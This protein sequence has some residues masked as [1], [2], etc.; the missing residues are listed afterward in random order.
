MSIEE[1]EAAGIIT[2]VEFTNNIEI[3]NYT[4]GGYEGNENAIRDV[5]IPSKINGKS[6]TKIDAYAFLALDSE[7]EI[8]ENKLI[9]SIVIPN[10]V[11]SIEESAFAYNEL[12]SVTIPKS[13]TA[14]E[15]Y[16]FNGNNLE[17]VN[18]PD[19]VTS[20]GE[21]AFAHNSLIDVVIPDNVTTIGKEAFYDCKSLETVRIGNSVTSIGE[22]AF[23]SCKS[24][25]SIIIPKSVTSIGKN[26]F[27]EISGPVTIN[28]TG[29]QDE[30]NS[31]Q[32]SVGLGTNYTMKYNYVIQ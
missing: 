23:M 5:I 9:N 7:E 21:Y 25:T 26:I 24:L 29:T 17:S 31:I 15:D 19:S 11:T 20:I 1:L 4:C 6:V 8:I 2:N 22:Y 12:E 13:V 32:I 16:T 3:T 30:W 18:I 14:I 27:K 28:Y 10:S